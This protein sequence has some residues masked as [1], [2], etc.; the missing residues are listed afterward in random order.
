[1]SDNVDKLWQEHKELKGFVNELSTQVAQDRAIFS[2][3]IKDLEQRQTAL[4]VQVSKDAEKHN[5][6]IMSM[7]ADVLFALK[8]L[9]DRVQNHENEKLRL[10]GVNEGA[11]KERKK[12]LGLFTLILTG[13]AI[14]ATVATVGKP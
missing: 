14:I 9:S 11:T 4:L 7:R 8:E 12:L 10:E 2:R 1:V 3:Q 6:S 13:I 5:A